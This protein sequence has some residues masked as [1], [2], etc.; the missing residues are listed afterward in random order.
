M[1][2]LVTGAQGFMGKNLL[3]RLSELG[4]KALSYTRES[5][6]SDLPA[7]LEQADFVFHL[8]GINRPQTDA[9]F[10]IGNADLTQLLC[11]AVLQSQ[12][13][14]PILFTSSTQV[15]QNNPYGL[16]KE[17]AEHALLKAHQEHD[18]P[19]YLYRLPNVFGKWCRPHYNS[20][21]A[22][23][24]H[25]ITHNLPIHINDPDSPLSLVYIDDVIDEFLHV[26]E[27]RPSPGFRTVSPVYQT[28]VGEIAASLH[29]FHQ[30]RENLVI[31]PVGTGLLRA[32]YSTYVSYYSP[33]DFSYFIPQYGDERGVFVEML[34]T[35][36]SGQISFFTAPPGATRG[37]HY[38]HSKTE[39][40]LVIK[41]Q[42]R[43]EFRQVL[44]GEY[45][46]IEV[47]GALP[48]IVETIPGWAHNISNTGT[49]EMM[50]ML[51]A[52]EIFNRERPD[53]IAKKVNA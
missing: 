21:V 45:V 20:A 50:V 9:E 34:K 36:D 35:T 29:A 30:N 49:D 44:T 23:F 41:G 26:L 53:T 40:F 5:Q 18:L 12:K 7:L 3:L 33:Q 27:A 2:V 14:I 52:N 25:N 43:F 48:Q 37:E 47:S 42:A 24:C 22:T 32:L 31:P 17:R 10:Q 19:V 15:E 8:A 51:W 46:E 11:E 4:I 16:S 38:H 13:K 28:R 1:T 39:K 6:P